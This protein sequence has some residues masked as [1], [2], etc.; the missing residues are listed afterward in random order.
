LR[1][2]GATVAVIASGIGRI[3]PKSARALSERIA[4]HGGAVVSEHPYHVAALPPY[5][6][7]RNRIIVGLSRA[8]VVV[9]SKDTGGALITAAFAT[10]SGRPLW[11]VPGPITSTR[12]TGTN[13][14]IAAGTARMLRNAD[15]VLA[16]LQIASEPSV[17]SPLP[18]DLEALG[19][20]PFDIDA[21][22]ECWR[23]TLSDASVRLL[24]YELAGRVTQLPGGRYRL[25]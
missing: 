11:S 6:P 22:A 19:A 2:K 10:Q 14:L 15:E 5:F 12:S 4:E 13:A 3:T 21:A 24:Q 8:V 23:T 1:W 17:V 18:P 9:E 20:D 16:D 25:Q 7:A